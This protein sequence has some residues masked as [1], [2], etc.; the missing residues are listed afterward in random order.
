MP[1]IAL[2]NILRRK[3]D[4]LSAE[5][6]GEVVVMAPEQGE[7]YGLDAIGSDIWRRLETP[8]TP[9]RLIADLVAAYEGDPA[10]IASDTLALLERLAEKGLL[11]FPA[12]TA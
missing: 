12:E 6:D 7:Y 3:A 11:I 10:A 1:S 4:A 2:Q 8:T 9:A 5:I